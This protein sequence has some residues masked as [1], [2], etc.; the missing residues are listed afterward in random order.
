MTGVMI[1]VV[2]VIVIVCG[3]TGGVVVIWFIE[4]AGT[5]STDGCCDNFCIFGEYT[6][7]GA[8]NC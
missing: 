8:F 7:T 2:G 1:R 3:K 4:F 5:I 6:F